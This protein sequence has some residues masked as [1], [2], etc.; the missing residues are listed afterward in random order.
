MLFS[1][2]LLAIVGA[3][4]Q[5]SLSPRRLCLFNTTTGAALQ[6]LNFSTAVLAIRLNWK[7]LVVVL[8]EKTYIYDLN[9]LSILD[10]IDTVP[11]SKGEGRTSCKVIK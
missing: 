8:Q 9:S 4:E 7:R 10:T 5:L 1:S 11:N 2:S 3:G 6:E